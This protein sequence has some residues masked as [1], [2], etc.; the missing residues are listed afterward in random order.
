[1]KN[2]NKS[3]FGKIRRK[4]PRLFGA[5]HSRHNSAGTIT[6]FYQTPF[7][8]NSSARTNVSLGFSCENKIWRKIHT[9]W[10]NNSKISGIPGFYFSALN[11]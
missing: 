3:S 7:A 5:E 10:R 4:I 1:M 6:K 2:I 9:I 11:P 8:A